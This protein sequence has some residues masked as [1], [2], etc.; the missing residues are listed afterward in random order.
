M[1]MTIMMSVMM[2]MTCNT[3]DAGGKGRSCRREVEEE[4]AAGQTNIQDLQIINAYPI[5][6]IVVLIKT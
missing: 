1:M 2:V 4:E 6:D 5:F 3:G